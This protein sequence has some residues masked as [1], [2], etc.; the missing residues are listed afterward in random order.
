VIL[1]STVS[2][3]SSER[4]LI[5]DKYALSEPASARRTRQLNAIE[6]ATAKYSSKY[7]YY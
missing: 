2:I 6:K 7:K 1:L 4:K 3:S 5:S